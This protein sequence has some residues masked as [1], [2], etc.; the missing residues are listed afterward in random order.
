MVT[1]RKQHRDRCNTAHTVYCIDRSR[2]CRSDLR[3]TPVLTILEFF[4]L[5]KV[6]RCIN[7]TVSNPNGAYSLTYVFCAPGAACKLRS[8]YHSVQLAKH[9]RVCSQVLK[10]NSHYFACNNV[11]KEF[12]DAI[13]V[14]VA[15]DS[16][17]VHPPSAC[18]AIQK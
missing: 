11:A 9:C 4:N 1:S 10:P 16:A 2:S 8:E 7:Q 3:F 13:N 5:E 18:I 12:W 14:N 6:L 15:E 17:E